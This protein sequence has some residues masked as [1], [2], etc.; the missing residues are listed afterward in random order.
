[1]NTIVFYLFS[2][3]ITSDMALR[4]NMLWLDAKLGEIWCFSSLT[5]GRALS[6]N[7]HSSTSFGAEAMSC[8][9]VSRM[10]VDGFG[11]K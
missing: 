9:I 6:E 7:Q 11:R 10:S 8:G 3:N 4:L 2:F 1:M 5:F